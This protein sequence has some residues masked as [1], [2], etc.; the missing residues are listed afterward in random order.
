MKKYVDDVIT[1]LKKHPEPGKKTGSF[2]NF[3]K[4]QLAEEGEWDQKHIKVIEKEIENALSKAD[5]KTLSELWK[6][7]PSGAE[8]FDDDLKVNTK[9]MKEDIIDE[10]IGQV[11]DRMDDNYIARDTFS[12]QPDSSYFSSSKEK[13]SDNEEDEED[14]EPLDVSDIETEDLLDDDDIFDELDE[15]DFKI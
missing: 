13:N 15:D 6:E 10:M 12:T 3:L 11:M 1:S 5:K 14:K 2:W 7:T 9:E 4:S 8:K